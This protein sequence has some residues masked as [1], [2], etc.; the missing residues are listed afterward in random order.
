MV[1][2]CLVLLIWGLSRLS[3]PTIPPDDVLVDSGPSTPPC[4]VLLRAADRERRCDNEPID[5]P[6]EKI[7]IVLL[8]PKWNP[9]CRLLLRDH[10]DRF[11]PYD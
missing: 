3:P 6:G 5:L 8:S 9:E 10:K 11:V 4:P 7:D 1:L 2:V